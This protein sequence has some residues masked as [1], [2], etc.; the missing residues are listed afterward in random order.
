MASK[1]ILDKLLF[2]LR[3]NSRYLF[4]FFVLIFSILYHYFIIP[5]ET[6]KGNKVSADKKQTEQPDLDAK[7]E[8]KA[9]PHIFQ[10]QAGDVFRVSVFS[11]TKDTEDVEIFAESNLNEVLQIGQW[12]LE[13]SESGEYKELFFSTP[14][15]YENII[16]RLKKNEMMD[17]AMN[18][19]VMNKKWDD[20]AVY[21]HSFFVSRVDVKDALELQSLAPTIFGI[22]SMNRV[23]LFSQK[24]A[25]NGMDEQGGKN[26]PVEWVFQAKGDFLQTMEFSGKTVGSGR[27]EYVFQLMR[28]FPDKKEKERDAKLLHSSAF[29]LDA[30]D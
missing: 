25:N 22:S 28:Y 9:Y 14:G 12:H 6:L 2:F 23:P 20:S 5:P 4:I 11:S 29:I 13:P 3:K 16:I 26:D 27:Q 19:G 8:E 7:H 30:L 1:I 21:I 17:A 18:N 15:R 10:S 24:G